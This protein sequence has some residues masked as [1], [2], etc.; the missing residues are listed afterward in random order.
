MKY[1]N[2]IYHILVVWSAQWKWLVI[3]RNIITKLFS[4]LPEY[5]ISSSWVYPFVRP[6]ISLHSSV[7][8]CFGYETAAEA[9]PKP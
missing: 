8:P 5:R 1:E 6:R 3:L 2:Y 7:Y 9:S 4:D